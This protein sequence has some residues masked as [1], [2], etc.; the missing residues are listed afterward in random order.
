[1]VLA[2][3]F[4]VI[5]SLLVNYYIFR[6]YMI[7]MMDFHEIIHA[8]SHHILN[9][10]Q[11][12]NAKLMTI[13]DELYKFDNLQEETKSIKKTL[14]VLNDKLETVSYI[15][16]E[17]QYSMSVMNKIKKDKQKKESKTNTIE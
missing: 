8:D 12:Y 14:D 16:K 6:R 10:L 1:M 17:E 11:N 9:S 3:V 5:A 13:Y 7:D 2:V 15:L 4:A